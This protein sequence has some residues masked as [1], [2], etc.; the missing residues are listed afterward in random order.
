MLIIEARGLARTFK[1]KKG[2]IHAVR[3]V[4]LQVER[5]EIVALLGPNGAGKSTT[6]RMLTTLLAPTAGNAMVAGA[7]LLRNP[8]KV[9]RRI[10]FVPQAIGRTMG[11]TD[12]ECTVADEMFDQAALYRIDKSRAAQRIELLTRQLDLSGLE[13]R[14]VKTLSGG[15]RRRLEIAL[16][17]VHQPPLVF[18]D[19]PTTALDPQS[20]ANMWDHIRALRDELGTT[21]VLTTHYLDEADALCDRLFIID[22][23]QTVTFGSP[24]ELKRRVSG[25]IV[26]LQVP[27]AAV[28]HAH[29][30][31]AQQ[32]IVQDVAVSGQ[33]SIRLNVFHGSEAL[34]SLLRVLD[35]ARIPLLSI[36]LSRPT[37]DDVFLTLTGRSLRDDSQKAPMSKPQPRLPAAPGDRPP[38]GDRPHAD[39]R[40]GPGR[41]QAPGLRA[42][43]DELQGQGQRHGPRPGADPRPPVPRF[44]AT[45]P[46]QPAVQRDMT[47]PR[48]PVPPRGGPNPRYPAPPR[49]GTNPRQQPVPP[50]G[51]MN[52][53]QPASR[54]G[55]NPR[56]AAPSEAAG[57]PPEDTDSRPQTRSRW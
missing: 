48:Q 32:P 1:N 6:L 21:I 40:Q 37:L 51:N 28:R 47:N 10:G 18:L 22:H 35:Y 56:H 44:E 4:D 55:R 14:L 20:R 53:G 54:G 5:G 38:A 31:L 49:D 42:L 46:R 39:P 8:L 45:N 7:N 26:T 57:R 23:G 2:P 43:Q 13:D 15:Q 25:D 12:N 30:M 24:D 36:N 27:P 41:G 16:G 17:L 3:R 50:R 34:P 19:E 11:G 9:R 52:P 29:Q 33:G